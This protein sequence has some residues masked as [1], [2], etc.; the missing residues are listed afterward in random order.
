MSRPSARRPPS[1]S[2]TRRATAWGPG[3]KQLDF[4]AFK[5]FALSEDGVRSLQFRAEFFNIFNTPQFNNPVA[6]IGA[7]GAGVITSAGSP[8]TFQ[9]LSREI[10]LALKFYF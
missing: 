10:Q 9:R 1:S 2:E 7:P 3:T 5:N 8:Y 4:S 6:T